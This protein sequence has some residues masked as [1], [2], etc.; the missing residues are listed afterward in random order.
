MARGKVK[1]NVMVG[2]KKG[3]LNSTST[4]QQESAS[5]RGGFRKERAFGKGVARDVFERF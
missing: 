1:L 3:K 2:V 5:I 4:I